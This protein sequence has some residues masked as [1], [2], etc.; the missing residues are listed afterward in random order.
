MNNSKVMSLK[1]SEVEILD[2]RAYQHWLLFS[3]KRSAPPANHRRA[4]PW[5]TAVCGMQR[6]GMLKVHDLMAVCL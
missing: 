3:S 1:K 2:D 6:V 5:Q 4:S